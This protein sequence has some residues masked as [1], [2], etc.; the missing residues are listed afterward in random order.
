MPALFFHVY[1]YQVYMYI[2]CISPASSRPSCV[3]FAATLLLY[4]LCHY[5]PT[6]YVAAPPAVYSGSSKLAGLHV[7]KSTAAAA[8]TTPSKAKATADSTNT[9]TDNSNNYSSSY[10][11]FPSY[12]F[13]CFV[14]CVFRVVRVHGACNC[15]ACVIRCMS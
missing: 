3:C 10:V 4:S 1:I 12:L 7:K 8:T 15:L 2:L 9:N 13:V 5:W 6:A 14:S 11:C